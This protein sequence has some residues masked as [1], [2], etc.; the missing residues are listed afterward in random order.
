MKGIVYLVHV[1]RLRALLAC[2]DVGHSV[3]HTSPIDHSK[4]AHTQ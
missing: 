4:T 2:M 3:K 1:I